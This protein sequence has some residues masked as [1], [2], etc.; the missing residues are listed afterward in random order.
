[1]RLDHVMSYK[2]LDLQGVHM[3]QD[4]TFSVWLCASFYESYRVFNELSSRFNELHYLIH[5]A[6]AVNREKR[7]H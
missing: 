3:L 2:Q 4:L 6:W 5:D 1:M 7:K